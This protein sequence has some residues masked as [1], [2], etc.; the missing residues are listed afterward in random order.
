VIAAAILLYRRIALRAFLSESLSRTP[1]NAYDTHLGVGRDPIGRLR[2]VRALLEPE[3]DEGADARLVVVAAAAK[4]EGVAAGAG[5]G[6]DDRVE[7]LGGDVALDGVGAV[8][9]GAP[10]EGG[11]VVDVGAVQQPLV[12]VG[13]GQSAAVG[14]CGKRADF[15]DMGA[16]TRSSTVFSSTIRGHLDSMHWMRLDSPS[17][18]ELAQSRSAG[19]KRNSLDLLVQV[20]GVA[21]AAVAVVA[22]EGNGLLS[23][24]I[25]EADLAGEVAHPLDSGLTARLEAGLGVTLLG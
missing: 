19:D 16:S 6:G 10:A 3:L 25:V 17:L 8:A 22:G 5:D 12:P 15:S 2:V 4:A 14:R 23:A 9:A 11:V 21:V 18:S 24:V 20:G 7:R 1:G 13:G